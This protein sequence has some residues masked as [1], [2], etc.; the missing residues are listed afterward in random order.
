M[1]LEVR[2]GRRVFEVKMKKHDK[3]ET[4]LQT[5]PRIIGEDAEAMVLFIG[6]NQLNPKLTLTESNLNNN[7]ILRM[8]HHKKVASYLRRYERKLL[9][10]DT[11][12]VEMSSHDDVS[13]ASKP[14]K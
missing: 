2:F 12:G 14:K 13:D 5:L 11:S 9:K 3:L 4:L 7:D 6:K 8:I 10:D 1:R